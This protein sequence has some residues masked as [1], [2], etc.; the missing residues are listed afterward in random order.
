MQAHGGDYYLPFRP[1][2]GAM[3]ASR[4]AAVD[5]VRCLASKYELVPAFLA[6]RGL[7]KQHLDSFDFLV[8]SELASIV[9]AKANQ[10]VTCDADP[11]FY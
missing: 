9:A 7:V 8:A 1:A 6:V 3:A 2:P 10:R 4:G 11:G 5:D